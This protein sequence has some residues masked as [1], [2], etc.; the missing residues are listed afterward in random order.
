MCLAPRPSP[1]C[2]LQS[3]VGGLQLVE[4]VHLPV[5][6]RRAVPLLPVGFLELAVVFV[7]FRGRSSSGV[8]Q[9]DGGAAGFGDG[10]VVVAVVAVGDRY[11]SPAGFT[12]GGLP[13]RPLP[14]Q[15]CLGLDVNND[16]QVRIQI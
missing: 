16:S 8:L 2:F 14:L 6:G 9:A 12:P 4:H 11:L 10:R 13:L 3:D 1:P 5:A 7:L 15:R